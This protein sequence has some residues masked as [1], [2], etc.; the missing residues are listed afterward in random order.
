MIG[1][2]ALSYHVGT[3]NRS[4]MKTLKTR[5][6]ITARGSNI[7]NPVIGRLLYEGSELKEVKLNI[8]SINFLS[9]QMGSSGK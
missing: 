5:I 1:S 3:I 2:D 8:I 6:T 4:D 7:V 9:G